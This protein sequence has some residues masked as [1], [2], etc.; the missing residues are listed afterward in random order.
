VLWDNPDLPDT[1]VDVEN[2]NPLDYLSDDQKKDR[3]L[4]ESVALADSPLEVWAT[5]DHI[6][7][8]NEQRYIR[9]NG[10]MTGVLAGAL[11]SPEDL[12]VPIGV[13]YK[14]YKSGAS[15]L[16]AGMITGSITGGVTAAQEAVLHE[17]QFTRTYGE[18][19]ANVTAAGLLGGVLGMAPGVV[20]SVFSRSGN[21]PEKVFREIEETMNPEPIVA[22]G[23]NPSINRSLSAAA[24]MDL[25]DVQ[26]RGGAA[27]KFIRL[28]SWS[29][30]PLGRTI[31]S[32]N[33]Q[34]RLLSAKLAE[35]PADLER[36]K[37][38]PPT[39]VDPKS[40]TVL[41]GETAEEAYDRT[42]AQKVKEF[43]V[44]QRNIDDN[45]SF[46]AVETRIT[47]HEVRLFE[48]MD[49]HNKYLI[50][51]LEG[52][53]MNKGLGNWLKKGLNR[54]AFN[55]E[56]A[57]AARSGKHENPVIEKAGMMWQE[58]FYKPYFDELVEMGIMDAS[59]DVKTA[60]N[61]LNRLWDQD[62]II[63]KM[64]EFKRIVKNWILEKN[65]AKLGDQFQD[66]ERLFTRAAIQFDSDAAVELEEL[67]RT[68]FKD[69]QWINEIINVN[70]IADEITN[71]I[72]SS[73]DGTIPYDYQIGESIN[74]FVKVEGRGGS[75]SMG[76]KGAFN[77]RSFLIPDEYIEDFL[78]N[79]ITELS[80]KYMKSVA[81]DMEL[82]KT[83]GTVDG[84]IITRQ[85]Q[86]EWG[87][88]IDQE[89]NAVKRFALT[90]LR[91]SEIE[92]FKGMIER[93][94]GTYNTGQSGWA[95]GL[96]RIF[97][98]FR[99]SRYLSL[100]GGVV[101]S[102]MPDA[103]K[104]VMSEGI[105]RT[106]GESIVP[107]ITRS[108]DLKMAREDVRAASSVLNDV[109]LAGATRADVIADVTYAV[110]NTSKVEKAIAT[111]AK[112]Y[113]NFNLMNYWTSLT[114]TT[115]AVMWQNRIGKEL[116]KGVFDPRLPQLGINKNM[117]M[118]IGDMLKEHGTRGGKYLIANVGKWSDHEAADIYMQAM[119]KESDRVIV[120][121]GQEK[122]LA[123]SR[124]LGA[125]MLQ[126][127]TFLA[128]SSLRITVS[129]LQ[130]QDKHMVEGILGMLALGFAAYAFKPWDR[131]D[132]LSDDPMVWVTEAIDRSGM[133]GLLGDIN[134][135]VEKISRDSWGMRPML[136]VSNEHN[137]YAFRSMAETQLGPSFG[138][139]KDLLQVGSKVVSSEENAGEWTEADTRALRRLIPY[140]NLMIIRQI[141]DKMEE[142]IGD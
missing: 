105:V 96:D 136:G 130:R 58:K 71:K 82:L 103:G 142:S 75:D 107:L 118:R 43:E 111:A 62:R 45:L 95:R 5:L 65:A 13:T 49:N 10:S 36:P 139:V 110:G 39:D 30:G 27:R 141:F 22:R 35:N 92:D 98:T 42:L 88:L 114:K 41:P 78:V 37:L 133:T 97:A 101:P 4:V 94:R 116:M 117:G 50:E 31:T 135:T 112:N 34:S 19:A 6:E 26:V 128:S 40:V 89:T 87:R 32:P 83:F 102:S 38:A 81:P 90:K 15:I 69:S 1:I 18:S 14:T 46:N 68:S 106:F 57:K 60:N 72:S 54:R 108:K 48:A 59:A 63:E 55:E 51:Y 25:D 73:A 131:G 119:R 44:E 8:E 64:P 76:L 16:K 61:Y 127:K 124:G 80:Y 91:E 125:T 132:E 100:M 9:D 86:D 67:L 52:Q 33:R 122:P 104:I 2:F 23:E 115:G 12:L 3:L 28:M 137:K 129:M 113:S 138:M 126:F 93:M 134:N 20:K 53:E 7:W 99:N 85:A 123:M 74:G 47:F 17:N 77:S 140:Q 56:V 29:L 11:L 84:D 121:P 24:Q 120:M 109:F 70:R 79:D 66:V 21:N